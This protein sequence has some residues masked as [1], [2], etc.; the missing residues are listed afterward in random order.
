MP[1]PFFP[2]PILAWTFY[3]AL[4]AMVCAAAV[5]DW[6]TTFVPKWLTLSLL[7][8]GVVMNVIRGIWMG[9]EGKLWMFSPATP[10]LGA[11][12]GLLLS[13]TGF[14]VAFGVFFLMWILGTCGGGDVKLFAALGAWVGPLLAFYLFL[15][16]TLVL[17]LLFLFRIVSAGFTPQRLRK[18]VH[19]TSKAGQQQL[20]KR[21]DKEQP[22]PKRRSKCMTFSFP[23]A[24]GVVLVLLWI[25]RADLNLA[26]RTQPG[27]TTEGV[28]HAR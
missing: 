27:S 8:A 13:L 21:S 28:V 12:D 9:A 3:L 11:L 23:V 22:Q 25:F 16:S 4:V 5:I 14:A 18:V 7:G 1:R 2:D 26:S 19:E 20:R 10:G 17:V 15:G 24:V 6:R